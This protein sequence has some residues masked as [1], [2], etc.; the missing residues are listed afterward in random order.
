MTQTRGLTIPMLALALSATA[1]LLSGCLGALRQE[2]E[3]KSYYVIEARQ[4]EQLHT[5]RPALQGTL[6]VRDIRVAPPFNTRSLTYR[7]GQSEYSADYYHLYLAQ[8]GDLVTQQVR[9]WLGQSGLF[10]SVALPGSGLNA[11]FI[12]E[13]LVTELYGDFR[14]D[15]NARA[16]VAAQFF[17][18][19]DRGFRRD[20][21]LNRSY[22]RETR[23]PER[24]PEG[25]MAAMNQA[26]SDVLQA[27]SA[28]MQVL[29]ATR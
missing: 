24:S 11:D 12:L 19:D 5:A 29:N 2:P 3:P 15:E 27:L 23:L 6:Q 21:I 8:P 16:V 13:G 1:V 14:D 26:F 4:A 7:S 18:L 10:Q 9:A 20:I 17:L 25:L 22:R 28:D